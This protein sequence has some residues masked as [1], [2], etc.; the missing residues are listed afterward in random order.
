[1]RRSALFKILSSTNSREIFE[2][3]EVLNDA[4]FF[5]SFSL[6]GKGHLAAAGFWGG[7]PGSVCGCCPPSQHPHEEWVTTMNVKDLLQGRCRA[8]TVWA[9]SERGQNNFLCYFLSFQS[10]PRAYALK[11]PLYHSTRECCHPGRCQHSSGLLQAEGIIKLLFIKL[12]FMGQEPGAAQWSYQQELDQYS[13]KTWKI[14]FSDYKV[15]RNNWNLQ[16]KGIF[17][18]L[19]VICWRKDPVQYSVCRFSPVSFRMNTAHP[20]FQ[21]LWPK[22]Q[23]STFVFWDISGI[24]GLGLG[25]EAT[26]LHCSCTAGLECTGKPLHLLGFFLVMNTFPKYLMW[27]QKLRIIP[28]SLF[29][30]FN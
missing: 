15:F 22:E 16:G 9:A 12:L 18:Y 13:R 24:N 2:S 20:R 27:W 29:N 4:T 30:T 23:L 6:P 7:S 5:S 1:M 26:F 10:S 28:K 25:V 3:L 19:E 21:S 17:S 8:G 14:I 11:K